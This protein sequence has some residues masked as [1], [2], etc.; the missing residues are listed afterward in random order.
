MKTKITAAAGLAALILS[1]NDNSAEFAS[2]RK[3]HIMPNSIAVSESID[4]DDRQNDTLEW[5]KSPKDSPENG[6]ASLK[7][8]Q[9][10]ERMGIY[11]RG[12]LAN[13]RIYKICPALER[14][15]CIWEY[16][17]QFPI[18]IRQAMDDWE[19]YCRKFDCKALEQ[20][21]ENGEYTA[22]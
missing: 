11:A 9:G 20:R 1:C 7:Y 22:Q 8:W 6:W 10:R 21:W 19:R 12:T 18:Y 4:K 14:I 5:C 17:S 3:I 13:P 16:T 2:K 15:D